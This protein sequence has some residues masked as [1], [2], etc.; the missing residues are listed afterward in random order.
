[1]PVEIEVAK[2]RISGEDWPIEVEKIYRSIKPK[3]ESLH[4]RV[5]EKEQEFKS[6]KYGGLNRF[7]FIC[8][9]TID[10]L[11]KNQIEIECGFSKIRQREGEKKNIGDIQIKV[12]GTLIFDPKNHWGKT[13]FGRMLYH[14]YS[15]FL[16][17][18]KIKKK[19][20]EPL[21]IETNKI[22][23]AIKEVTDLY[24]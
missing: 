5:V 14:F 1:M 23:D 10:E 2:R 3:A 16:A 12:V 8:E 7:S 6:E 4:Y 20:I 15:K 19:Y 11:A 21:G 24:Q 18:E 17:K 22:Y 13:K 9:K